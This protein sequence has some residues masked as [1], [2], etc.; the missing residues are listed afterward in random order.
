MGT[1]Q[2]RISKDDKITIY[3]V[4]LLNINC[5]FV[6]TFTRQEFKTMTIL[7][8]KNKLNSSSSKIGFIPRNLTSLSN[9]SLDN[10]NDKKPLSYIRLIAPIY[11]E[12]YISL[13]VVV[14]GKSFNILFNKS[15]IN[16]LI[17]LKA[18]ISILTKIKTED[19]YLEF[20]GK[21][22]LEDTK[23]LEHYNI[24]HLSVLTQSKIYIKFVSKYSPIIHEGYFLY[25]ERIETIANT[26]R[27]LIFI[28]E[29]ELILTLNEVVLEENLKLNDYFF[30]GIN[31]VNASIRYKD[32]LRLRYCNH[33]IECEPNKSIKSLF[34]QLIDIGVVF[35]DM[36][37]VLMV[38]SSHTRLH[39]INDIFE[40]YL[41]LNGSEIVFIE[42][43]QIY[44]SDTTDA[45][46]TFDVDENLSFLMLKHYYSLV[47]GVNLANQQISYND[48]IVSS[49]GNDTSIMKNMNINEGATLKMVY[50]NI[51]EIDD[52]MVDNIEYKRIYPKV[53]QDMKI[54]F[55]QIIRHGLN[56][57]GICINRACTAY[58][59][60]INAPIKAE[61]FDM[62][63]SELIVCP[64]CKKN[65]VPQAFGFINCMYSY[66]FIK[67]LNE[68]VIQQIQIQKWFYAGKK[69]KYFE[70]HLNVNDKWSELKLFIKLIETDSIDDKKIEE[71]CGFCRNLILNIKRKKLKCGHLYHNECDRV[72]K[73]VFNL[74]CYLCNNL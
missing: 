14:Q 54:P 66:A 33:I 25:N 7:D 10:I 70:D 18:E 58:K 69:F 71:F 11:F 6:L 59:E 12:V 68:G 41:V 61:I 17:Q 2:S 65:F 4:C 3:F 29:D 44:I 36:N 28:I 72:M 9:I 31:I 26:I 73:D 64:V 13:F 45:T 5:S 35:P 37:F 20:E 48:M 50:L 63:D 30:E 52:V 15:K 8:L 38:S 53:K 67:E 43:Y 47:S 23:S 40:N 60:K 16:T 19:L 57:E 34:N 56:I 62:K 55:W 27:K 1:S 42:T 32:R 39:E 24:K 51:K 22:L 46:Y 21:V 74:E 49:K